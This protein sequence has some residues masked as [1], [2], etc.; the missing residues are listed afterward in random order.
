MTMFQNTPPGTCR[1]CAVA[2]DPG[3]PHNQRSLAYQYKFYDQHGR[4]P[5]WADAMTHC[6]P[7]VKAH[8]C[9]AL[10]ERGVEVN[11]EGGV[12]IEEIAITIE[13]RKEDT[14]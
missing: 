10:A 12:A 4:F 1:E 8:W 7:E 9:E 6:S 14:E 13:V 2:H 5:I 3:Q 11:P